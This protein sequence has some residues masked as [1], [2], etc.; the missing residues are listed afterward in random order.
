LEVSSTTRHS[1]ARRKWFKRGV[2]NQGPSLQG[3][4]RGSQGRLFARSPWPADGK[5]GICRTN[6]DPWLRCAAKTPLPR[7]HC[8]TPVPRQ[9]MIE[10][11]DVVA[12]REFRSHAVRSLPT[13]A[14][15]A[16][17]VTQWSQES[18]KSLVSGGS[19]RTAK[20][21]DMPSDLRKYSRV[22]N[23]RPTAD[24]PLREFRSH[25]APR[26][27]AESS[28]VM[29]EAILLPAVGAIGEI[30]RSHTGVAPAGRHPADQP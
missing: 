28:G 7:G 23:S 21:V 29:T 10:G 9:P 4:F 26:P 13:P 6:K 19:C 3:A 14:L 30:G 2:A 16:L 22:G 15:T 8:S 12:V 18:R 27:S 17:L 11:V 5:H 20:F 24:S 1:C 25:L